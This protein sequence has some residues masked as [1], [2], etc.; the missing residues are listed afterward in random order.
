MSVFN[1]NVFIAVVMM[2]KNEKKRLHVTLNSIKNFAN[3]LIVFDTGSTDETIQILKNF[4]KESGIPLYLKEGEF[5]NF[6]ES[7]NVLLDFADTF[8]NV[9]YL[10]LLDC[11]DELRGGEYLRTFA[12]EHKNKPSTGFLVCQEWWSGNY[13]K[14]YN[15]RFIKPRESWRYCG[16]VHEW[17]K[18]TKSE[19]G[20]EPSVIR[21]LDNVVIYQDRTQD[22]DKSEKRFIRDKIILLK[23][24]KEN[25][26]E[27][28]TLF[29]LAQTCLCLG[30]LED[31]FYY[32][33]L[34][35]TV[36]GFQEEKF[37]S[38]NICGNIS[39]QLNHPWHDCMAW[40]IKAFEHSQRVEPLIKITEH[41]I[42]EKNWVL[43]FTFID[44]AC[45]LAYPEY[46]ILFVD[47]HVYDYKRWHILGFVGSYVG[48]YI[49][50]KIGC[51]KA[52]ACGFNKKIDLK[53]L[54]FYNNKL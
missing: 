6:S 7:R 10:L 18:N 25:P 38:F 34:R 48:K 45:S 28:R 19:E 21:I 37:L 49:E 17:L 26:T 13:D 40:Y 15:M 43:A 12:E 35:T 4:S 14:Y 32:Y 54:N 47:K 1:N 16:S 46:C 24:H 30:H 52:I 29:Y 23:E 3:S 5:I 50:G 39:E 51:E 41:Y 2:V 33:K 20:K 53:I 11:N 42:Q 44:L 9:D 31:A 36:E 8:E 27:P 22:D